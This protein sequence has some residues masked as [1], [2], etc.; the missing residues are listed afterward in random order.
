[1]LGKCRHH[2]GLLLEQLKW[3]AYGFGEI[4]SNWEVASAEDISG[5]AARLK[6]ETQSAIFEIRNFF[7]R[8]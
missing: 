2:V 3:S 1:M 7:N 6:A 4:I 5:R 8:A